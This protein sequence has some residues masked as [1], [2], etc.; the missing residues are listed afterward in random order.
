MNIAKILSASVLLASVSAAWA[1]SYSVKSP[2]GRL[3][4]KINAGNS[5]EFSIYS[6]GKAV[7]ENIAVGMET[8][9]GKFGGDSK[10]ARV[11]T[12]SN[13][14]VI[15]NPFGVSARVPDKY[16]QLEMDFSSFKLIFRAYDEAIAYRFVSSLGGGKIDV[17]SE[18]LNLPVPPADTI[19]VQNPRGNFT[20]YEELFARLKIGEAGEKLKGEKAFLLPLLIKSAETTVAVVESD[21]QEYPM[22]R[23]VKGGGDSL[24]AHMVKLPKTFKPRNGFG[25]HFMI[26]YDEFESCIARTSASRKFPWRA[27]IVARGDAELAVNT[28]V[29][30]LAEP[31]RIGDVSW[32]PTGL[33]VWDWWSDWSLEG[34]GFES[35]VNEATY[36]YYI[37][38]AAENEIPFVLFDA[39]WLVGRDVDGMKAGIHEKLLD[40][41]PYL[42][43]KSLIE[44]A[45]SKDVKVILWC[46][47]QSL[48]LYAEKAIP[49]MKSWGAD[50]IKPDFIS[51][52]DQLAMELYY[53]I[54]KV[55][56]ENNMIVDIHGCA[57]PAGLQRTYPNVVNFEAVRGLE[58][59]KMMPAAK[60][61][62]PSHDV[63]LV[64]TRMLQGP[65]D[66]TPG[67]MRNVS[68]K[69]F[70]PNYSQPASIGTRAH[71]VAL[72]VLFHAPL[73]MLCDSPTEYNKYP[74][75]LE[76]M[77][78]IPTVWDESKPIAG[79][80]GEYVAVA[81]RKGDVWYLAGIC[82]DKG[83]YFSIKLSDI[84]GKGDYTVE[85]FRDTENSNRTP[86]DFKLE[87]KTLT[88]D[89]T[90]KLD[91]KR[92]GGFVLRITPEKFPVLSEFVRTIFSD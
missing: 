5:I 48:N 76:F 17:M 92:G 15:E 50:G 49:L 8:S 58:M 18:T 1:V 66:Y 47:G 20:S 30:K 22:L 29:F 25:E 86:Q 62:S 43:V 6:D 53:R 81:R 87:V 13:D 44:Y 14:A 38:F 27:F 75:A 31:S 85:I 73:Q 39:G 28:T 37:D 83:K 59:N 55:A 16:N 40:G 23:F 7:L 35:G 56:A 64:M 26:D 77:A 91:M 60:A 33:C 82:G 89:D 57:K 32:I 11:R 42:D 90:L 9:K 84:V 68:K 78:S 88:D 70:A 52:D 4:A 54:A 34:V 61:V 12:S 45:H 67:A 74:R 63:D 80:L 41:K 79:K 2:D 71:Q 72:Y 36:R 3:E 10:I 51:R 19:I 24:A 65:M 21:V 46:L 69:S